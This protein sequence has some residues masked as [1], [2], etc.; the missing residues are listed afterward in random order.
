MAFFPWHMKVHSKEEKEL[1]RAILDFYGILNVFTTLVIIPTV[2]CWFGH[3]Y[4]YNLVVIKQQRQEEEG[5]YQRETIY[6]RFARFVYLSHWYLGRPLFGAR[7]LG[8]RKSWLLGFLWIGF[9]GFMSISDTGDDYFHLTKRLGHIATSLLPA[10]YLLSSRFILQQ[11]SILSYQTH[12]TLNKAHRWLGRTIYTL[13]TFHG[14]LYTNYFVTTDRIYRFLNWDVIFGL[15]GLIIMNTMFI[16]SLPKYRRVAYKTFFSVHQLLSVLVLPVA[17][18]HVYDTGRYVLLVGVVY[19]IDRVGRYFLTRELKVKVTAVSST[20][21]DLR[22]TAGWMVTDTTNSSTTATTTTMGMGSKAKKVAPGSHFY[23]SVPSMVQSRGNPFTLSSVDE[24][25]G[26]AKFLVRVRDGFTR[27]LKESALDA[28]L[29]MMI[30]GP[31]GIAKVFPGFGWFDSF[32]FITGGIGITMT[33]SVLRELVVEIEESERVEEKV[34]VRFVWAVGGTDDAAW[35]LSE[36][37]RAGPTRCRPEVDIYISGSKGEGDWE[38]GNEGE[39]DGE[40]EE[41]DDGGRP[42]MELDELVGEDSQSLLPTT[43]P[44]HRHRQ[45]ATNNDNGNLHNNDNSD[46]TNRR[47]VIKEEEKKKMEKE[48]ESLRYRYAR[49]QITPRI[50]TGRPNLTRITEEF[51]RDHARGTNQKQKRIGVFVCGPEGMGVDVRR[52]LEGYYTESVIWVWDERFGP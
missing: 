20:A 42:S 46:N 52:A 17:W 47:R 26:E 31:Y 21:L 35:P 2:V 36:L 7:W 34:G 22:G 8:S 23:I 13:L 44:T 28:S 25:S 32:L 6:S 39:D 50:Q 18:V 48:I 49:T 33:L 27:E 11:T 14:I 15:L 45:S 5:G 24:E 9:M 29:N 38:S 1:R 4:R 19:I 41:E 40:E 43:E 3:V 51:C 12:E 10:Q 37:L 16:A 30:E